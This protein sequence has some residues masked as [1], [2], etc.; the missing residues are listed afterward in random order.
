MCHVI[1]RWVFFCCQSFPFAMLLL[2]TFLWWD[3]HFIFTTKPK[4]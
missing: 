4:V 1:T 2:L 3:V